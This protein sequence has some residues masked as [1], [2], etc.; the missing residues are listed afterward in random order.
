MKIALELE[1]KPYRRVKRSNKKVN[2]KTQRREKQMK[3]V[4]FFPRNGTIFI[5]HRL[6]KRIQLDPPSRHYLP[7]D[8]FVPIYSPEGLRSEVRSKVEKPRLTTTTSSHI[9][10]PAP[11]IPTEIRA[12]TLTEQ[13]R[14]QQSDFD[15]A[16]IALL[17]DL[18]NRDL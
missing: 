8:R 18:Q 9:Y 15:D 13:T 7:S 14:T 10:P 2:I 5:H 1:E 17:M 12:F 3:S 6:Y 11:V 16:M 4:R